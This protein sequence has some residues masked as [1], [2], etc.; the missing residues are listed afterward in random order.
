MCSIA[1]IYWVVEGCVTKEAKVQHQWGLNCNGK[2]VLKMTSGAFCSLSEL[3][4]GGCL[5]LK[6]IEIRIRC[7]VPS[8]FNHQATYVAF[9]DHKVCEPVK[10]CKKSKE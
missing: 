6:Y 8:H 9:W 5:N 4:D 1:K 2:E 10:S 7:I 3:W